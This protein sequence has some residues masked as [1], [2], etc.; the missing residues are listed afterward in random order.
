MAR[1]QMD[2]VCSLLHT[3]LASTP[4]SKKISCLRAA[5]GFVFVVWMKLENGKSFGMFVTLLNEV[6]SDG[7]L[8]LWAEYAKCGVFVELTREMA[9]CETPFV[10][11][12]LHESNI[13]LSPN[14]NILVSIVVMHGICFCW[15]MIG[16]SGVFDSKS[17]A[18]RW[19]TK[20]NKVK[21]S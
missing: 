2:A 11:H 9:L 8:L 6:W 1:L 3:L 15:C 14:R 13:Y 20:V 10:V 4:R 17:M 21:M 16:L 7:W 12:L 18:T 5:F 19:H